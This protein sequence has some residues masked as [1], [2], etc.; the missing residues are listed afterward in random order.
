MLVTDEN[1]VEFANQAICDYFDLSESPADLVGLTS[2]EVFAKI[3][4]AYLYPDEAIARVKEIVDRGQPVAERRSGHAQR[5]RT[6]TG[7]YPR[8][9]NGKSY[10]RLWYHTDIT[11]R[12]AMERA[13]QKARD[14]LEQRV[15]E[16]TEQLAQ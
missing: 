9:V 2:S 16:R 14:D 11:E 15:I 1:R 7:F 5:A 6:P 3:T 4:E 8:T 10:G 13:L 12:K